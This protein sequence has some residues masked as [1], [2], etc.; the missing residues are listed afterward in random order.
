MD[1]H[2][3]CSNSDL[4]RG[5]SLS[6]S[7]R[8]RRSTPGQ[9]QEH[10]R[11]CQQ[12]EATACQS[13][14]CVSLWV[15]RR[16]GDWEYVEHLRSRVFP[17]WVT[18]DGF[19]TVPVVGSDEEPVVLDEA[20]HGECPFVVGGEELYPQPCGPTRLGDQ[21]CAQPIWSDVDVLQLRHR[22]GL[23]LNRYCLFYHVRPGADGGGL[24]VCD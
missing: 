20:P 17:V 6:H 7:V 23:S 10:T 12:A 2:N 18:D 14:A 8:C 21:V 13:T 9:H 24:A 4:L 11:S 19:D 5:R 22:E 1:R 15:P 3:V 16:I